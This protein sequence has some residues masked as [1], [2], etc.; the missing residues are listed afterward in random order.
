MSAEATHVS[1]APLQGIQ[2]VLVTLGLSL[3][4][5]MEVLDIAGNMGDYFVWG[6]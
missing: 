2:L 5:F 1:P 4:V 3:A 6:G